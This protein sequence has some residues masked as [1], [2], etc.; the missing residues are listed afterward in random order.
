MLEPL[1][2]VHRA[3]AGRCKIA[4]QLYATAKADRERLVARRRHIRQ[5]FLHIVE[6]PSLNLRW[7]ALTSAIE[8][9][10]SGTSRLRAKKEMRC[11][12][13]SSSTSKSS[14]D[15]S[16]DSFAVRMVHAES[17]VHQ[18]DADADGLGIYGWRGCG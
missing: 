4:G 17:H 13:P 1:E 14:F 16:P 5:K 2:R 12:T 7:L 6:M 3:F 15:R 18:V 10:E 9:S 11:G 8:A